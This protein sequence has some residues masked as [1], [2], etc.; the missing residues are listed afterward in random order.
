[1]S[2]V[3]RGGCLCGSV[4]FE[5]RG[6]PLRALVC[7]CRMC[8]RATGSAFSS[9]LV[10]PRT[11]VVFGGNPHEIYSYRSPEHGRMLHFNFCRSCGGR[12]GLT[13][14]RFPTVHLLYA[15]TFDDPIDAQPMAQIF[16]RTAVPWVLRLNHVACFDQHMVDVDGSPQIPLART[17][18]PGEPSGEL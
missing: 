6:A 10:F 12:L 17:E 3:H 7:H 16:T 14:D 4:R 15:G 9:E 5:A 8:Q 1:M 2:L 11:N 18:S 13:T